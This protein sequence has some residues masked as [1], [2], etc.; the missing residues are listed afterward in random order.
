MD[1]WIVQDGNYGEFERGQVAE[2]A[3]EFWA[4]ERLVDAPGH[5]PRARPKGDGSYAITG[6]VTAIRD[7]AWALDCGIGIFQDQRPPNGISV[8]DWLTGTVHL[9]IDPFFYFERLHAFEAF[10]P[11]IY[12]WQ[13]VNLSIQTAPFVEV[14]G[15]RSRDPDQ[16]GWRPIER[17]DA[18]HDDNGHASYLLECALLRPGPKRT[19]ATAT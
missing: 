11:L 10:P 3:V 8:G 18:W 9:G 12:T 16:I 15:V 1:A 13:I 19:S 2:L 7:D 14:R 6:Q 4:T 5:T 17:T